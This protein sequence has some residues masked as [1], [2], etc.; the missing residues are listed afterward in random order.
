VEKGIA[1]SA[2]Q[3]VSVRLAA[4]AQMPSHCRLTS[5]PSSVTSASARAP[6]G[7][8]ENPYELRPSRKV[9]STMRIESS[10]CRSPSFSISFA[11]TAP[12]SLSSARTAK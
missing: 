3:P 5:R 9:S 11:I 2:T 10:C 12:G 6:F 1:I 7:L 4:A 8:V